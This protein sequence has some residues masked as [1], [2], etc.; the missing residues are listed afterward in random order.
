MGWILGVS[1]VIR[2]QASLP[3]VFLNTLSLSLLFFAARATP[4]ARRIP[5]RFLR[6]RC[7]PHPAPESAVPSLAAFVANT[8]QSRSGATEMQFLKLAGELASAAV[9]SVFKGLDGSWIAVQT[10]KPSYYAGETVTG[11]VSLRRCCAENSEKRT[12]NE[13]MFPLPLSLFFREVDGDTGARRVPPATRTR[14]R[15]VRNLPSPESCVWCPRALRLRPVE[16]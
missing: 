4:R 7:N 11:W 9:S 12:K 8:Q 2:S 6:P 3:F 16:G 14:L 5:H 13:R 1:Q 15:P 10:E